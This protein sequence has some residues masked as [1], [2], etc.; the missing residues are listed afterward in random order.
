MFR[1]RV[2]WVGAVAAVSLASLACT[3]A[4]PVFQLPQAG[5]VSIVSPPSSVIA[6]TEVQLSAAV[7]AAQDGR[8]LPNEPRS[9][10][11][12]N[13]AV[14]TVDGTG[15]VRAVSV[16]AATISVS[17]MSRTASVDLTVVP[18]PVASVTVSPATFTVNT[19]QTQQMS[20]VPRD[21]AGNALTGR[22]VTWSSTNTSVATV[23][24]GGLLTAVAAG[25]TTIRATVDGTV[26]TSAVTVTVPVA[27]IT[28]SPTSL[29]LTVGSS[30]AV[31]ATPRD[32]SGNPLT[33]RSVSWSSSNTGVAIVNQSGTVSG[34]SVGTAVVTAASEGQTATLNVTVTAATVASVT[35]SASSVALSVGESQAITAT[36]RDAG[37]NPLT[38]RTVTWSSSNA[39]IATVSS[40]GLVTGVAVGTATITATSEGR[41][42]SL[43]AVI[44]ASACAEIPHTIGS[45][46]NGNLLS[47][48]C[49]LSTDRYRDVYRFSLATGSLV[50]FTFSVATGRQFQLT[51]PQTGTTSN[52]SVFNGTDIRVIFGAGSH[53][54]EMSNSGGT[55]VPVSYSLSSSAPAPFEDSCPGDTFMLLGTGLTF[56]R[57]LT[58]NSCLTAPSDAR[59]N[60][61]YHG[62]SFYLRGGESVDFSMT[63]SFDNYLELYHLTSGLVA[64]D[65]NTSGTNARIVFTAPTAGRY[66]LRATTT[67]ASTT[68]SYTITV[69]R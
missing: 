13:A 10:T 18:V 53:R 57:S 23:S 1:V 3:A 28:F 54:F 27:T 6:G 41:S 58:T 5:S 40:S 26:G 59:P 69:A 64:S 63:S 4:E 66:V 67:A 42:A 50:R 46:V 35:L 45:T 60:R 25:S 17:A 8:L 39:G 20:A 55:T 15:R 16:G 21:A 61:W 38:G 34:V 62:Y 68:G 65:D 48:S 49:P 37:N 9:W 56:T 2:L 11:T 33:G 36:P 22:S 31:T 7:T 43:S 29:A 24:P 32:A 19:G 30:Q 52:Y 12:S 47:T 44:A 14:A 51:F